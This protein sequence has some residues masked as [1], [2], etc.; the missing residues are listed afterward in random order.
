MLPLERS[1]GNVQEM[2]VFILVSLLIHKEHTKK[3]GGE[4]VENNRS[5]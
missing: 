4:N 3:P 5:F 2:V 1:I